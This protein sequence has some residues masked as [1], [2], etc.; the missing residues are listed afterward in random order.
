LGSLKVSKSIKAK[1]NPRKMKIKYAQFIRTGLSKDQEIAKR[2]P[3]ANSI[4]GYLKDI[5]SL[6]LEHFP[7]KS[8]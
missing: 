6:Q 7:R 4:A 3:V 5:G 1:V 8:M 2:M